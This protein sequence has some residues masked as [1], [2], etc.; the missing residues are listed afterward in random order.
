VWH[1]EV[2][3]TAARV[4]KSGSVLLENFAELYEKI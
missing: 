2:L 1:A 4:K 3:E